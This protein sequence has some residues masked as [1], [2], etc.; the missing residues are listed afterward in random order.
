MSTSLLLWL[1]AA[2]PALVSASA[3]LSVGASTKAESFATRL[4]AGTSLVVAVAYTFW[5]WQLPATVAPTYF[6]WLHTLASKGFNAIDF[7]LAPIGGIA[8][9]LIPFVLLISSAVQG[10]G[11]AYIKQSDQPLRFQLFVSL[12]SLAMVTLI[13]ATN[14]LQL[15][16]AW[17][18]MGLF[19]Y[20][21][22]GYQWE[23]ESASEASLTAFLTNRLADTGFVL[24]LGC[25]YAWQ[26]TL[27]I[28]TLLAKAS[29]EGSA[30]P[31]VSIAGFGLL[32]AAMGKSA[33]LLFQHWLRAAM[34]GPTPSSALIHAATMVAAGVLLLTRLQGLLVPEVMTVIT[35][36]G[37]STAVVAGYWALWPHDLKASLAYSTV[38]QLGFMLASVPTLLP[39][40]TTSYL[41]S[42][43]VA[44][45]G[46]FLAAGTIIHHMEGHHHDELLPNSDQPA[47]FLTPAAQ[48]MRQMPAL[49]A[50]SK[51]LLFAMMMM[52]WS[53][54]GGPL[55]AGFAMKDALLEGWGIQSNW[56][57]M[58]GFVAATFTST[59]MTRLMVV[60]NWPFKSV[61][62]QEKT[63]SHHVPGATLLVMIP[64]VIAIGTFSLSQSGSLF[65]AVPWL[66]KS[67][68]HLTDT[69][70][71]PAPVIGLAALM[72]GLLL[73]LVLGRW[74]R[75]QWQAGLQG[76]LAFADAD[77]IWRQLTT[78]LAT[79]VSTAFS[80]L[81]YGLDKNWLDS[82][83]NQASKTTVVLGHVV[84]LLELYVVDGTVRGTQWVA[85][86]S[87]RLVSAG[88][89]THVQAYLGASLGLVLLL[90][91]WWLVF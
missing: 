64:V 15:F 56:H 81:L 80:R 73:G 68:H 3:W 35:I 58:L 63:T 85:A 71:V 39:E 42:H 10:Y 37:F 4:A 5:T 6:Q 75:L 51:P 83:V 48:D 59:Y 65:H 55:S 52:S 22:I 33:Q 82:L 2:L 79:W 74:Q 30:S 8:T 77:L 31:L 50:W 20:L 89:A 28:T 54:I 27:D 7:G 43:G 88:T 70:L 19:S 41:I 38:S 24:A 44:K 91:L 45:A 32:L 13:A 11:L 76:E 36:I 53:M 26:G 60:L 72:I 61:S 84:Q 40:A 1:L 23:K 47:Y 21:L 16:M 9:A 69:L 62:N 12:F 25:L 86:K 49:H 78:A 14:L 66:L 57:L 46:L 17:E 34:A 67:S 29:S 18:L 90:A 87:G